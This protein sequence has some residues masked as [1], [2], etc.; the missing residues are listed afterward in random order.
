MFRIKEIT[1][2][3]RAWHESKIIFIKIEVCEQI[4]LR[5]KEPFLQ[6]ELTINADMEDLQNDL[7][8][9]SVPPS[10]TKRAYPSSLGLTNW[11]ADMLN[12]VAELVNWTADFNV[13]CYLNAP[14]IVSI[15]I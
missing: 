2:R 14:L 13:K 8:I 7:F 5:L 9:D 10:W 1:Q 6:G 12:R 15:P 3:I 11:F 4:V